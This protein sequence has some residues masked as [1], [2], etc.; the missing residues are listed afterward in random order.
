[1][2][3]VVQATQNKSLSNRAYLRKGG[4]YHITADNVHLKGGAITSNNPS[5]SELTT[6][7]IIF[8]DIENSSNYGATSGA[9]SGGYSQSSGTNVSPSL[10]MHE[11]GKDSTTTK[12]TLTE[13]KITLNKDSQPTETTAKALGINTDLAQA[14]QQ[15][16]APK[17]INQVLKEQSVIS[18]NVGH[19]ANAVDIFTEKLHQEAKEREEAAKQEVDAAR[20]SGDKQRL[21]SAQQ[22]YRDAVKSSE[23]WEMGANINKRLMQ[24]RLL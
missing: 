4:G 9:I 10:P 21:E 22:I 17:D 1:M 8:S 24:L 11:Q 15:V 12:A 16:D 5:N 2:R 20:V 13:G 14:N 7:Q 18:Q 3:V 19:I 23:N 6:N